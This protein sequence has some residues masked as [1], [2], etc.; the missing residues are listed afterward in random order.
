M[1]GNIS[2]VLVISY[3]VLSCTSKEHEFSTN[4]KFDVRPYYKENQNN[5][6]KNFLDHSGLLISNCPQE[7]YFV[8]SDK[9]ICQSC[10]NNEYM[11][12]LEILKRTQ[13]RSVV[14]FND[15]TYFRELKNPRVSFRYFTTEKLKANKIFHSA[16]WLYSFSSNEL[17]NDKKLTVP[18]YDSLLGRFKKI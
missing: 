18:V 7:I 17:I 11:D 12:L 4:E 2:F 14:I 13:I 15:S 16:T 10:L 9:S 8:N 6:V 1:S 5:R 3:I